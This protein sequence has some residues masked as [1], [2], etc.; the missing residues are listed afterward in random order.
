MVHSCGASE[1]EVPMDSRS[2]AHRIYVMDTEAFDFVLGTD[3]FV[4]H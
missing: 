1:V 3:L 2:I 4:E